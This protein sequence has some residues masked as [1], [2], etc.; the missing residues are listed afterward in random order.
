MAEAIF[1]IHNKEVIM[2]GGLGLVIA[3]IVF[4]VWR[5]STKQWQRVV[6]WIAAIWGIISI[7]IIIL[8]IIAASG[9]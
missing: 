8:A 4:F 6:A 9:Q 2:L 3:A 5:K 7:F 1:F